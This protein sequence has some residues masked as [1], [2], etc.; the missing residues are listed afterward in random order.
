MN[1]V[2]HPIET[3]QLKLPILE[4][5]VEERFA[6]I[7]L[8]EKSISHSKLLNSAIRNEHLLRVY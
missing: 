7:T 5:N 3:K 8:V 4:G 2:N 1:D 6:I